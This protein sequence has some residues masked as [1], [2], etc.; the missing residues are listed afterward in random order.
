[1]TRQQLL[2][3]YAALSAQSRR[4]VDTLV[5]E[6]SEANEPAKPPNNRPLSDEPFVGMWRDR[7]DMTDGT[8]WTR[9]LRKQQRGR[10]VSHES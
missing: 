10:R 6:L 7:A 9:S 4:K 2:K 3:R 8:E 1:M 5:K